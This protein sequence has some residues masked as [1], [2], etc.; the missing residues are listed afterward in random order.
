MRVLGDSQVR[1]E[2]GDGFG[3]YGLRMRYSFD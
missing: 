1:F 3:E 2:V